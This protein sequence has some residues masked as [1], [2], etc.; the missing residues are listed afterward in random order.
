MQIEGHGFS[1]VFT[2]ND[3]NEAHLWPAIHAEVHLEA[4]MA[5]VKNQTGCFKLSMPMFRDA[6]LDGLTPK[7][8]PAT[9]A[10]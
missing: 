3:Q 2:T 5:P 4:K 1:H 8:Q 7:K 9:T 10:A 6:K